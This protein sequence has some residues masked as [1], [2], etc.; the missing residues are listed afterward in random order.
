MRG[1]LKAAAL[2]AFVACFAI[3]CAHSRPPAPPSYSTTV[4]ACP[5]VVMPEPTAD[6]VCVV[7]GETEFT[8]EGLACVV[9]NVEAGC[10][11]A[12]G[13]VYCTP[14]CRDSYCTSYSAPERR[15]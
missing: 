9:C 6:D 14:T 11:H 12:E 2:G 5:G 13:A 3:A 1:W 10:L 8:P 15:R 7:K 4:P